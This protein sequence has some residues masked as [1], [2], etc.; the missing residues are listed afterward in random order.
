MADYRFASDLD[1]S[2]VI[3][4]ADNASIPPVIENRDYAAYLKWVEGG[5]VTDPYVPPEIPPPAPSNEQALLF[6]H[7]NR[8]LALEGLPPISAEDFA[9][10]ARGEAPAARK[11][12]PK[13]KG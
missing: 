11:V 3:R 10:K 4:T 12:L 5:G 2:G 6:E 9:A 1:P 13:R 7:E 8:I